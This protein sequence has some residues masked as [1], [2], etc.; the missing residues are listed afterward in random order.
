MIRFFIFIIC[1]YSF[2]SYVSGYSLG[3][4]GTTFL[5]LGPTASALGMS[6]A[7]SAICTDVSSI[8]YNPAGLSKLTKMNLGFSYRILYQ[9]INYG[10]LLIGIPINNSFVIGAGLISLTINNIEKRSSDTELPDSTFN[11]SDTAIILSLTKKNLIENFSIG[12][13]LKMISSQLEDKTASTFAIDFGGLYKF[14][15]KLFFGLNLQNIGPGIKFI[16]E[17]DPLPLS[18]NFGLGYVDDKFSVGCDINNSL[19]ELKSYLC[20]GLEYWFTKTVA[21]RTGYK[22][23]YDTAGLGTGVGL[24]LGFGLNL[25]N[26]KLDIAYVPYGYLGD[27]AIVSLS[28]GF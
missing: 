21:L 9:D 12:S 6:E 2:L 18:L 10:N 24:S 16:E 5:K 8:Y 23:G 28:F 4:A 25:T 26:L 19:V 22:S 15:D 11:T 20:L 27:T 17:T 14:N 13:N 7:Y 3:T 1:F